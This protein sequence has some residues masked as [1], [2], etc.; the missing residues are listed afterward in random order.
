LKKLPSFNELV[1]RVNAIMKVGCDLRL[2]RRYNMGG[3]R[4]IHVMLPLGSK[5]EWQLYKTYASHLGLKGV[6]VV[7]EMAPLPGNEIT[8]YEMGMMTEET[9]ADPIVVEQPSEEEC[10]DVTRR[11][12]L[13]SELVKMNFESLNL[14]VVRDEF[15][16]DTFDENLDNEHHVEENDE[17]SSSKS[18]EENMQPSFDTAPDVP[19]GTGGEGN[20]AIVSPLV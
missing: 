5:N 9:I 8:M 17:P 7:A 4:P 14:V 3:N 15:D 20:E 18:D 1:A 13:A 11:V 16:V 12:S 19:V 6:E 2:H 10:Q